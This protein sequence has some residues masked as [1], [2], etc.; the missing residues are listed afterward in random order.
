MRES[1]TDAPASERG[2]QTAAGIRQVKFDP[3]E[4][5]AKNWVLIKKDLEDAK[6]QIYSATVNGRTDQQKQLLQTLNE[7]IVQV[8]KWDKEARESRKK[9]Q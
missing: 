1:R 8:N 6:K 4:V 7:Y 3:A 2:L 9:K 5:N